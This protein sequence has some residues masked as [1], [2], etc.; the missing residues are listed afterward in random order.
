MMSIR[1]SSWLSAMAAARV[2]SGPYQTQIS[3]LGWG[4]SWKPVWAP[5]Q[6]SSRT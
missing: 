1:L 6:L 3:F 4:S 5:H 2:S